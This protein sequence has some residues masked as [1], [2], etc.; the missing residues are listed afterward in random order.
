MCQISHAVDA[1][2]MDYL[3]SSK[4]RKEI[5]EKRKKQQQKELFDQG[6]K[7]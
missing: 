5:D 6:E 4:V 2:M 7:R 3:H 1:Y